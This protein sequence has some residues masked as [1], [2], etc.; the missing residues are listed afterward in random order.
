M[1]AGVGAQDVLRV[2]HKLTIYNLVVIRRQTRRMHHCYYQPNPT[3]LRV[4]DYNPQPYTNRVEPT[5]KAD[6]IIMSCG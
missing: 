6:V 5:T 3:P 2:S 1:N 4:G